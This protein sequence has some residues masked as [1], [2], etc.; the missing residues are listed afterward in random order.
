MSG[1]ETTYTVSFSS[2]EGGGSAPEPKT[3]KPGEVIILSN[4]G[5]MTAPEG[6]SF[7]GWKIG[8]ETYPPGAGFTVNGN[9]V[10][11][12]TWNSKVD[13]GNNVYARFYN[14]PTGRVDQNGLLEIHTGVNKNT[15]LFDGT[16]DPENYIGTVKPLSSVQVKL[17]E[18]KF[19]TIVAV[20]KENYEERQAQA[21]QFNVLTYYSNTQP[22]SVTVSPTNTYGTGSWVFDNTTTFW[23]QIK[24]ADMSQNFAVLA[25]NA[26]RVSIP[27]DMNTPYDYYVFFSKELRY[28]GKTVALVEMTDRSQS[29]TALATNGN[30]TYTT[31]IYPANVPTNN[32]KP[33]VMVKNNSDKSVRVYY[34]NNQKT[35]GA[36]GGDL[37]ITGGVSQLVSGFETNDS[38]DVI[39]FAALAW[40]RNKYVPVNMEMQANKVYEITIPKSEEASEITVKEVEASVYYN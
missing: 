16:P 29:N 26:E 30:P 22:Y 18:E 21:A 1:E 2:G 37:V 9:V 4:Q 25:P 24:K 6:K 19:Y 12:A 33:A 10:L 20:D 35:N 11:T 31:K 8:N 38:T 5:G 28:N 14:Y 27:I 15:L 13:G 17:P 3:V 36:A 34:A 32:V 39:N 40:E 23:V 7:V